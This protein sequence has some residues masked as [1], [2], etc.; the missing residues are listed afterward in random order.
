VGHPSVALWHIKG[1][2]GGG[3]TAA[4]VEE[5][6]GMMCAHCYALLPDLSRTL[7]D[8]LTEEAI[9]RV[10]ATSAAQLA[11][12]RRMGAV[13][14]TERE[15][16]LRMEE[17]LE[18]DVAVASAGPDPMYFNLVVMVYDEWSTEMRAHLSSLGSPVPSTPGSGGEE[19]S[20]EDWRD[21]LPPPR[22]TAVVHV[23]R[24]TRQHADVAALLAALRRV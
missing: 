17:L 11:L 14:D 20:D 9:T 12:M 24:P 23:P 2:G 15:E 5:L 16:P 7:T 22:R 13:A 3:M 18:L 21:M 4:H 10:A 19:G 8:A 6:F 1:G